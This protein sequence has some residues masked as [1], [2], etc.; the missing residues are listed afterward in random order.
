MEGLSL[1]NRSNSVAALIPANPP[2]KITIRTEGSSF[3]VNIE[4]AL[5]PVVELAWGCAII[6][7]L[8]S[9]GNSLFWSLVH[10]T[11]PNGTDYRP[12][13][14]HMGRHGIGRG[15][16][17]TGALPTVGAAAQKGSPGPVQAVD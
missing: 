2:P 14:S 6:R 3:N 4:V 17:A 12:P 5:Q 10:F 8:R 16:K 1:T 13:R 15:N 7:F 11:T 9:E